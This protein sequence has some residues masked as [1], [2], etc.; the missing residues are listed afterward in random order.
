MF[1]SLNNLHAYLLQNLN[2]NNEI[3][4]RGEIYEFLTKNL[5]A[6]EDNLKIDDFNKA[7]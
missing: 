1:F 5:V 7:N 2:E 3:D 4:N 6:P